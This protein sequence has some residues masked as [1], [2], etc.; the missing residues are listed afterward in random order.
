MKAL[1][2]P[3]WSPYAV[4]AGIGALS[5]F[6]FL[7][8]RK[9]LGVTT[10]FEGTAATL[11]RNIA[12]GITGVNE[13][14]AVVEQA[15]K[16]D[17]ELMLD[18]GIVLGSF[19]SAAASGDKPGPEVPQRWARRFGEAPSTRYAGAFLGGAAAMFGARMARGCT[20]GHGISGNLQLA[21]SSLLFTPVMG[22]SAMLV[23]R[24]LFGQGRRG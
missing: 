8:A 17:W 3:S 4:G 22:L 12:P 10:A 13:Y 21:S 20:S 6:T 14:L 16:L 24:S 23:A 11:A 2:K 19:L 7:S 15:P 5:W 18:A 1:E 9:A